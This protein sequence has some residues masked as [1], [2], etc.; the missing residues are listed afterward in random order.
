MAQT[1]VRVI[2]TMATGD[3][4]NKRS[5][6]TQGSS[7]Y[8][9][10]RSEVRSNPDRFLHESLVYHLLTLVPMFRLDICN[11]QVGSL[12]LVSKF[13]Q[14]NGTMAGALTLAAILPLGALRQ[15]DP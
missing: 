2:Y 9:L 6:T 10:P 14:L 15:R 11:I 1:T 8:R 3:P 7:I 4:A 5:P 12:D 13:R